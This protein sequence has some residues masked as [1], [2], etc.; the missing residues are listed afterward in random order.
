MSLAPFPCNFSEESYIKIKQSLIK[1]KTLFTSPFDTGAVILF[2]TTENTNKYSN[3][4]I[5]RIIILGSSFEKKSTSDE[6]TRNR[7]IITAWMVAKILRSASLSLYSNN[8][9]Q[10]ITVNIMMYERIVILEKFVI[11]LTNLFYPSFQVSLCIVLVKSKWLIINKGV[12]I[13]L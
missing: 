9:M 2:I 11:T 7:T 10:S 3:S 1:N 4:K 6:L 12:F 5:R 13:R 8:K